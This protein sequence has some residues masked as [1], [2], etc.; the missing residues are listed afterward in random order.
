MCSKTCTRQEGQGL[1]VA[2]SAT[3]SIWQGYLDNLLKYKGFL[4]IVY[5]LCYQ[6]VAVNA[7][8]LTL[9]NQ[10]S[11]LAISASCIPRLI[12]NINTKLIIEMECNTSDNP[13]CH[14]GTRVAL[15]D[16]L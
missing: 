13:T 6:Q 7:S 14:D 9:Q 2:L 16:G 3:Y 4:Q 8:L 10:N 1:K 11:T 15:V 5:R 12:P